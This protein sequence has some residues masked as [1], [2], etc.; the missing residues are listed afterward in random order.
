MKKAI[1]RKLDGYVINVIEINEGAKYEP[2]SGCYLLDEKASEKA[3]IGKIYS[4][5]E[6]TDAQIEQPKTDE[7][8]PIEEWTSLDNNSKLD[9]IAKKLGLIHETETNG[10][11]VK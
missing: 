1:I 11:E 3:S 6:Y 9:I 5:G 2:S 4:N 10:K 7:T 8:I